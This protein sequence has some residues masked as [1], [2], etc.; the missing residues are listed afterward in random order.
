[1]YI[2]LILK[3]WQKKKKKKIPTAEIPHLTMQYNR[4]DIDKTIVSLPAGPYST[5]VFYKL[6]EAKI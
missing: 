6:R 5:T 1:M 4:I 3:K 2:C